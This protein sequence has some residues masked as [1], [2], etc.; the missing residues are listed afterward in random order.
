MK[1]P[2]SSIDIDTLRAM[3]SQALSRLEV[4]QQLHDMGY[5]ADAVS[6]VYYAAFHAATLLFYCT[7]RTFSSHAQ[8]IGAFNKEFAF[9]GFL[10]KQL[11][12][13]LRDL[14]ELQQGADYDVHRSMNVSE[15]ERA[16]RG[17]EELVNETVKYA[18]ETYPL[19]FEDVRK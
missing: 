7:G 12:R 8:L 11:A 17:A 15:S 2:G 1:L 13:F 3:E 9:T 4:A 10:P 6:R 19:R 16:L 14:Y 5:F 18:H